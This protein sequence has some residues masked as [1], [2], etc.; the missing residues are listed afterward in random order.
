MQIASFIFAVVVDIVV[1]VVVDNVV[2]VVSIFL[3]NGA[4]KID[5]KVNVCAV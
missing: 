2:I 3:I 1:I 4:R 5:T